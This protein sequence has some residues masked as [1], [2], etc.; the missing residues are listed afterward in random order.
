MLRR[1]IASALQQTMQKLEIIV[2]LDGQ[3]SVTA[4]VVE[5]FADARIRLISVDHMVGGSQARN[6]GARVAKGRYIALLD[7][8]DEWMPR[9]LEAQLELAD[10]CCALNFV[11]VSE[12]L[13]R[14]EGQPDEVWPAHLPAPGEPFSEFLFSSRGGFQTS[15]YLC[16]REL[17]LRVPFTNGLKKHQDWDWFLKLAALPEFQLLVV[18]EP[19]SIYWVPQRSRVSV[20]GQLDWSFSHGWARGRLKLM[21]RKAYS[22]FLVKICARS[23]GRGSPSDVA[24]AMR[25]ARLR[26]SDTAAAG[27]VFRRSDSAGQPPSAPPP[28][29]AELAQDSSAAPRHLKQTLRSAHAERQRDHPHPQASSD[30]KARGSQRASTELP[31][32]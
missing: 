11:V 29:S 21:T 15:T 32:L 16:P 3:D 26:P 1:A 9:K 20:S 10:A 19:H 25:S 6:I 14:V 22:R 5:E 28:R 18:P 7:D 8:D 31:G 13:Y 2:V 23:A 4:K 27:R 24:P 12:Y 17:M 30:A